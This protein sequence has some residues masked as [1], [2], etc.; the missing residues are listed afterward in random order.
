MPQNPPPWEWDVAVE[1]ND[2]APRHVPPNPATGTKMPNSGMFGPPRNSTRYQ[3]V[4]DHFTTP[5]AAEYQNKTAQIPHMIEADLSAARQEVSTQPLPPAASLIR[6][7]GVRNNVIQRKTAEMHRQTQLSHGFYGSD[8]TDKT[9]YQFLSRAQIVDK[10]LSPNGPGMN[11]WKQSYRA[12]LEARLLAQTLTVLHQQQANVHNWLTTVQANEQAQAAAAE[13]ARQAAERARIAAEQ[14]RQQAQADAARR[15]R[16]L[17]ETQRA[18]AERARI[19][20]E[21]QRQHALAEEA[22]HQRELTEAEQAR[23][24][25]EQEAQRLKEQH[26]AQRKA[27]RKKQQQARRA[28]ARLAAQHKRLHEQW[29]AER[30]ARWQN[31]TFANV[32]SMAAFDSTFSGTLGHIATSQATSLA[33]RTALRTAVS[34]V[35]AAAAPALVGFAALLIPSRL[36]NGDLYSASVPLSELAPELNAVDLYERATSGKDVDLPVR[37]G[38]RTIGNRAEIVVV[39]TDGVRV[40]ANVPVRLARFDAGKNAYISGDAEAKGPTLTWTPLVQPLNPSTDLP[41][42]DTDLPIY[43]GATVTPQGGR[44][45]PFPELDQ[46]DFG[47]FITVF[48]IE[49]GIPPTFTIFRDR[50]QDP[51]VASGNG[52]VISG[53]WLG[54]ASTPKGAPIPAQIADKLRGREFSSFRLFREAFWKSVAEDPELKNQFI[55]NNIEEMKNGRAPFVRKADRQGGQVKFELHHMKYI[56]KGGEVYDIENIRIT[57]PKQHSE[58]HKGNN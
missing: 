23:V 22:R 39:A 42:A 5:L 32:G 11:L 45:D 41:F 12:A 55:G 2:K 58:I 13:A 26:Q 51:G 15:Q 9:V 19:A 37:L 18:A 20:A 54:A 53:N 40:P 8:P 30:D 43:E 34:V 36:G 3:Q 14:Q 25:R 35:S 6:E 49:S 38:S 46:Y 17:V 56:S 4:L 28:K 27:K 33:L 29:Q 57:T 21:Q 7:L 24:Q 10:I 1:I 31:P 48:P 52:Q 44:I 47:G 16:E 50:R